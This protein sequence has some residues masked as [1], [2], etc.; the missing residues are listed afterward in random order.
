MSIFSCKVELTLTT[1]SLSLP[2]GV[3]LAHSYSSTA[4]AYLMHTGSDYLV[5]NQ[6]IGSRTFTVTFQ[7][8]QAN[9]TEKGI[10]IKI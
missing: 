7:S 1:N 8:K 3:H 4:M 2:I 6:N 9:S 5:N 10:E